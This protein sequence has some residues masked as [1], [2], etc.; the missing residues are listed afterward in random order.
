MTNPIT[1]EQLRALRE[2]C[3]ERL[4]SIGGPLAIQLLDA[5]DDYKLS[6]AYC[7]KHKPNGGARSCCQTCALIEA[8]GV[9]SKCD[10]A[11]GPPNEMG[12]SLFDVEADPI[13]ARDRILAAL[14]TLTKERNLAQAE[15]R[16]WQDREAKR[17][18][19]ERK[20]TAKSI[21]EFWEAHD[22]LQKARN[23]NPLS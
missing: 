1:I 3:E 11:A 4:C 22:A 9:I 20:G 7:D 21:R 17:D 6:T 8:N 15:C 16:I 12:V 10:Y 2:G 18:V 5:L 13:A 23:E 19:M 14:N